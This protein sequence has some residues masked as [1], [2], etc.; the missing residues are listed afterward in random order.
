MIECPTCKIGFSPKFRVCPRCGAYEAK[1]EDRL[2]HLEHIAEDAL[3]EGALPHNVEAMLLFEGLPAERAREII[4]A[5]GK[6]VRGAARFYGLKRLVAGLGL[7][8]LSAV[9]L[10]FVFSSS[11]PR[12]KVRAAVGAVGAAVS[13]A[14]FLGWGIY[15]IVAGRR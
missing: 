9:L 6:K 7:L 11:P 10:A 8:L 15:S 1:L 14:G 13:G 4:S 5:R 2:E 3:D 12:R